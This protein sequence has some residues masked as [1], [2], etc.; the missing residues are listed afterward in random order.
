MLSVAA[1][2]GFASTCG[3]PNAAAGVV[4]LTGPNS[5]VTGPREENVSS[6]EALSN[7]TAAVLTALAAPLWPKIVGPTTSPPSDTSHSA[8]LTPPPPSITHLSRGFAGPANLSITTAYSRGAPV[9]FCRLMTSNGFWLA[10]LSS[11]PAATIVPAAR[12]TT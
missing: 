8:P 7:G 5:S 4:P 11:A 12:S 3:A 6:V 1:R 10:K 2:S 9:G